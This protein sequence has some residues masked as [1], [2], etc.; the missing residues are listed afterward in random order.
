MVRRPEN[1]AAVSS[2]IKLSEVSDDVRM[3]DGYFTER[4]AWHQRHGKVF[5]LFFQ[6]H[7]R[8]KRAP[9]ITV[10]VDASY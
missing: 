4:N 9:E 6:G 1:I 3:G 2:G 8:E 10:A 7:R 5:R